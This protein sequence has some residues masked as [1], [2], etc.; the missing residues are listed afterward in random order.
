MVKGYSQ[1]YGIDYTKVYA[2]VARMDT[3]R[4]IIAFAAQKGWKL[5]QIDVKSAFLHGE[6]KEDV[7]VEQPEG[8]EKKG[9]E[10]MVYKLQKALYGLKQAPRAWFSRIES[11]F[12]KEGFESSPSE[13]TLFVKRK[14]GK[15]LIVSIYVDDLLFTSDDEEML[16]EF[17]C[18]MKKEFGMTDLGKM[19]FFLGIEV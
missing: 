14:G 9:G 5:Y 12:I 2:P 7:F 3:V 1:Q 19:R 11:Y 10:Q 4:M 13:Q 16:C 18:S 8:Y 17:K 6:L 15:I